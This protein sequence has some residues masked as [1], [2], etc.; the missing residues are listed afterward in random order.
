MLNKKQIDQVLE[1]E[2]DYPNERFTQE[3]WITKE[4]PEEP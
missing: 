3:G 1:I 4:E 2:K